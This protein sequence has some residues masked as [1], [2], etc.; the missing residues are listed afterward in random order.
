M[1][2]FHVPLP[3]ETYARLR[4][5]AERCGQPATTVARAAIQVW[6]RQRRKLARHQ[7]VAA[8]AAECAGTTLRPGG[9][10]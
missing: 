10:P 2:N 4:R 5:E 6:L 1:R 3:E 7:A 8:F 9:V